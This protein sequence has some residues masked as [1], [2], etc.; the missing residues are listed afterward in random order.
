MNTSAILGTVTNPF[1]ML[2]G[3][4]DTNR[5]EVAKVTFPENIKKY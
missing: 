3:Y 5:N 1:D 2:H 4:K